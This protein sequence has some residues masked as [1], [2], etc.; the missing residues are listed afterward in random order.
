MKVGLRWGELSNLFPKET[1][2]VKGF[3]HG[4]HERWEALVVGLG[5]VKQNFF[6]GFRGLH[7]GV[8]SC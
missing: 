2:G 4:K 7:G 5:D 8:R 6:S 3:L 1:G